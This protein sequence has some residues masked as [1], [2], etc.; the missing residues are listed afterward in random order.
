MKT[1]GKEDSMN[2]HTLS[3]S[4]T[5]F[6]A[7][8]C[9]HCSGTGYKGRIGIFEGIAMNQEVEAVLITNPS[10][11]EIN[12]AAKS[13][14][15]PSLREDAILKMLDGLTSFDEISRTVDLYGDE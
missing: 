3:P 5:L 8:G 12:K 11:R 10:E 15:I 14:K 2:D 4:Y 1:S 6:H 9:E 13:Q 7:P